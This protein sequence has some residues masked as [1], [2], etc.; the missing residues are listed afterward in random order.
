MLFAKFIF[1]ITVIFLWLPLNALPQENVSKLALVIGNSSYAIYPLET[2]LHDVRDISGILSEL[3]FNVILKENASRREMTEA[4]DSFSQELK[5]HDIGLFF[6]A[7]HGVQIN[8]QNYL[9]PVDASV[10]SLADVEFES[11]NARRL[12]SKMEEAGKKLNIIILDACRNNPFRSLSR[13][14][15][16][17][18]LASMNA[19]PGTIIAYSTSPGAVA[20]DGEGRNSPYSQALKTCL[21]QK[22]V[23]IEHMF[24]NTRR[25][26]S[27]IT[28]N[29][30]TPWE[31]T[32]LQQD[33]MFN[34]GEMEPDPIIHIE[35]SND[36]QQTLEKSRNISC[37]DI[38]SK[39]SMGLLLDK[40]EIEF[41]K[42][43][44]R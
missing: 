7:G 44:C 2:P 41:A 38:L 19:P 34:Q 27:T 31:S 24:K 33:F 18:G 35:I 10:D 32:S 3:G 28:K 21:P 22:G 29:K 17:H 16:Y 12:M 6:F 40:E 1:F 42:K 37:G 15:K 43:H 13:G 26:V 8:G 39:M 36:S 30:Q 5:H 11:V 9:I 14:V 4:I 23:S 20:F 25:L